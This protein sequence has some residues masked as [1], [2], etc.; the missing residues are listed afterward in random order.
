MEPPTSLGNLSW[1]RTCPDTGRFR[2]LL[3]DR[4][5]KYT[6]SFDAVFTGD[7]VEIVLTPFRAPRANAS[8]ERWVRTVRTE[9]LDWTLVLGRRHL[10]R[11]LREFVAATDESQGHCCIG[12]RGTH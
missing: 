12:C 11:V 4:D 8:A 5:S 1:D 7:G 9:C 10:E 3:V 6:R 2:F